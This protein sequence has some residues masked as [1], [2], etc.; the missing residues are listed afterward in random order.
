MNFTVG[1]Q[2]TVHWRELSSGIQCGVV[3]HSTRCV[4]AFVKTKFFSCFDLINF[5]L[6]TLFSCYKRYTSL[7][8]CISHTIFIISPTFCDICNLL[9]FLWYNGF[10]HRPQCMLLRLIMS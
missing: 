4:N 3:L 2:A 5:V 1:L 8:S 6:Q 7:T 10:Y 9:Y